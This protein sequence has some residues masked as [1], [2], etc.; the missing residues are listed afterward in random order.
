MVHH[1][2]HGDVEVST[3][4]QGT[5]IRVVDTSMHLS[6]VQTNNLIEALRDAVY[7]RNMQTMFDGMLLDP[8]GYRCIV[9]IDNVIIYEGDDVMLLD[10][11]NAE[12]IDMEDDGLIDMMK[13]IDGVSLSGI[14][15]IPILAQGTLS[16][17]G[18][19]MVGSHV[20][21]IEEMSYVVKSDEQDDDAEANSEGDE[22]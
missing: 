1:S 6:L 20:L 3:D 13:G 4:D 11:D 7:A 19:W 15:E 14:E 5:L 9:N 16:W 21:T 2:K 22:W 10:E 17:N 8:H 12:D 18:C